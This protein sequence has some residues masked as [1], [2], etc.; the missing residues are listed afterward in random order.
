M[1]TSGGASPPR[2]EE[3]GSGATLY[4]HDCSLLHDLASSPRAA[5]RMALP[6]SH[7][8]CRHCPVVPLL[9]VTAPACESHNQPDAAAATAS[10]CASGGASHRARSGYGLA[11]AG[12]TAR[13]Q[14]SPDMTS[15]DFVACRTGPT[16]TFQSDGSL[17]PDRL[18]LKPQNGILLRPENRTYTRQACFANPPQLHLYFGA[19]SVP[20]GILADNY[21]AALIAYKNAVLP[22]QQKQ[23][24]VACAAQRSPR[25]GLGCRARVHTQQQ[26]F[27]HGPPRVCTT[28]PL[29]DFTP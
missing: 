7:E 6:L 18:Y 27:I 23:S 16:P 13:M 21:F 28:T 25:V 2:T 4:P 20:V 24:C 10:R 26:G 17:L 29:L 3:G 19:F 9:L 1:P 8:S 15:G 12:A 11:T 14:V 22:V 5:C